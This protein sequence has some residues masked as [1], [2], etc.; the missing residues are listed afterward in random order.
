[1]FSPTFQTLVNGV[2]LAIRGDVLRTLLAQPLAGLADAA[3]SRR[4]APGRDGRPYEMAGF[5]V[6]VLPLRG[7][8]EQ[9][10][11]V[12][13]S[14]LGGTATD[15]FGRAFDAALRDRDVR[16]IVLDIDSPG[17]STFGVAELADKVYAARG[18]KPVY[19]IANSEAGSAAYWIASAADRVY[20]T[21]GCEVGGIG[22][23]A[24]HVDASKRHAQRGVKY[25]LV[26]A[27]KHKAD[28]TP[29]EPLATDAKAYLQKRVD[30]VYTM[31]ARGVARNLDVPLAT[32]TGADF[33]QGR[34]VGAR[35]AVARNMAHG[36]ATLD[37]AL[38]LARR[39]AG[40]ELPG[41]DEAALR[42]AHGTALARRGAVGPLRRRLLV[43]KAR[44]AR[45]N[46]VPTRR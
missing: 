12:A 9:R 31:L 20:I 25:T 8:L 30:D 28:T 13:V 35:A 16:A 7:P 41:D 36:V 39:A 23:A 17:G 22:V 24:V 2:P 21:P 10:P 15:A 42:V 46:G 11:G 34:M 18:V 27:G 38:A 3:P 32:V 44:T 29:Y 1:M 40:R 19:A 4:S 26:R 33:A 14:W 37:D 6:A 43:E 45:L 5:G